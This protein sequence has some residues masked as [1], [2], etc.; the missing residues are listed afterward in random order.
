MFNQSISTQGVEYQV[1]SLQDFRHG[2][3]TY[4]AADRIAQTE[5]SKLVNWTITKGGGL[6]TRQPIIQYSTTGT[7]SYSSIKHI[8]EV[9]IGGTTY[10][11]LV[12]ANYRLYYL[13]GSL[14]TTYI[15]T[16]QGDATIISYNNVAVIMDG[17]YLK[18]LDGVSSIKICYDGGSGSTGTQFTYLSY[19]QDAFLPLGDGTNTRVAQKFTSQAFSAGY[20]IPVTQCE[21]YLD[22]LGAPTG[23]VTAVMRKVS[24]GSAMA[25]KVLCDASEAT[26][27][28]PA[29]FTALF[30]SSDVTVQMSPSTAYYMSIEYAGGDAANYVKVVCNNIGSGGLSYYY[31]GS[32]HADTAKH[33]VMSCSPG[34]PPKGKFGTVWNRRLFVAGD[35]DNLGAAWYGNLTHLDWSTADGGGYV[36]VVDNNADNFQIGGMTS[37]YGNLYIFGTQTQP[38]LVKLSGTSPADYA[39]ETMFQRPWATHKTLINAVNDIWYS[40]NEGTAPISGVQEYGDLRS[41]FA[42]DPV[43]DRYED[44]WNT[45]AAIAGYYSDTGQLLLVLN[46]HRVLVFHTKLAVA[47]PDQSSTRYPCSEFELYRRNLSDSSSGKWL[48]SSSGTNEYYYVTLAGGNPFLVTEPD[49]ITMDGVVLTSGTVGSL[50]DHEWDYGNNDALGFNTVYVRDET[51]DPDST[52]VQ[53]RVLLKPTAFGTSGDYFLIGASNGYV[54]RFDKSDYK[55]TTSIQ[56]K[57]ILRTAYIEMPFSYVNINQVQALISSTGGGSVD[58]N[59]YT[60]G[61]YGTATSNIVFPITIKDDLTV[62]EYTMDVSDML[63][64]VSPTSI[65]PLFRYTNINCRS[66]MLEITDVTLSGYPMHNS[67]IV[68]K[69]RRLS[70]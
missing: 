52:G 18:Y 45:A 4:V 5:A 9:K 49:Y 29:K 68:L 36:S 56:I 33:C 69:Y 54:Y 34:S 43:L 3:N 12:D 57:P 40:T 32:W 66:I 35:P 22:K 63:F 42:S 1:L 17:N 2:L 16:L 41:F 55:D 38:Y 62:A 27:G 13:N 70:Y 58:L 8:Q 53:I 15:G 7:I 67:G 26:V 21:V 64:T 28:T 20:T 44:Y 19:D 60:D 24:D 65:Q 59:L 46:Y 37:F 11:L 10:V 47:A 14:Q 6:V 25:S 30:S 61:K 31:D 48:K 50:S 51:G 39:Q 23:S